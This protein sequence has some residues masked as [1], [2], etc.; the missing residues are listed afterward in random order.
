MARRRRKPN[1]AVQQRAGELAAEMRAEG[2]GAPSGAVQRRQEARRR[3]PAETDWGLVGS[4]TGRALAT[5]ATA[6]VDESVETLAEAVSTK[7][8]QEAAAVGALEGRGIF[9][10]V[11]EE[12]EGVTEG[13]ADVEVPVE[14]SWL[15][16]GFGVKA[17]TT[18]A[19][20]MGAGLVQLV[21]GAALWGGAAKG[22]RMAL[23]GRAAAKAVGE[24]AKPTTVAKGA[25]KGAVEGQVAFGLSDFAA[26]DADDKRML[27]VMNEMPAMA[28]FIPDFLAAEDP[29]DP[30]WERR[31]YRMAEG[32]GLGGL[33]GGVLGGAWSAVRRGAHAQRAGRP[34]D[35]L[36]HPAKAQ[37]REMQ[38]EAA[39]VE[40]VR[41]EEQLKE[42]D[43][44]QAVQATGEDAWARIRAMEEQLP[45][46]EV[47]LDLE[48]GAPVSQLTE[49]EVWA[50][51]KEGGDVGEEADEGLDVGVVGEGVEA[52][53]AAARPARRVLA[54][55]WVVDLSPGGY[56]PKD[57]PKIEV[58]LD[59][60]DAPT[61][62]GLT[63][64]LALPEGVRE[65]L[66]LVERTAVARLREAEVAPDDAVRAARADEAML[67]WRESFAEQISAAREVEV[68]EGVKWKPPILRMLED[69]QARVGW[70]QAQ[71]IAFRDEGMVHPD[72]VE[73]APIPAGAAARPK[74]YATQRR[75]K[76]SEMQATRP[77]DFGQAPGDELLESQRPEMMDTILLGEGD[78]AVLGTG[79]EAAFEQ[80][81]DV[82]FRDIESIDDVTGLRDAVA[83]H[84]PIGERIR[85]LSPDEQAAALE[86]SNLKRET[87]RRQEG[88]TAGEMRRLRSQ[89]RGAVKKK[90]EAAVAR[91][92]SELN[93]QGEFAAAISR[94]YDAMGRPGSGAPDARSADDVLRDVFV[95]SGYGATLRARRADLDPKLALHMVE[96]TVGS[97]QRLAK[98]ASSDGASAAQRAI[99]IRAMHKADAVIQWVKG[100][101]RAAKAAMR[102]AKL[103]TESDFEARGFDAKV[104]RRL[105]DNKLLAQSGGTQRVQARM[106]G[107][108]LVEDVSEALAHMNAWRRDAGVAWNLGRAARVNNIGRTAMMVRLGGILSRPG[109]TTSGALGNTM[110]MLAQVPERFLAQ[111]M[112]AVGS[113]DTRI[114]VRQAFAEAALQANDQMAGMVEGVMDGMRM[115]WEDAQINLRGAE[116]GAQAR[117]RLREKGLRILHHEMDRSNRIENATDNTVAGVRRDLQLKPDTK[118]AA[119][120]EVMGTVLRGAAT[121]NVQVQRSVDMIFKSMN[122]RGEIRRLAGA[123]ARAAAREGEQGVGVA[124]HAAELARNPTEDMFQ[125][126]VGNAHTNTFTAEGV[127]W[128]EGYSRAMRR[129]PVFRH[130]TPIVKTPMNVMTE[131]VKRL[132]FAHKLIRTEKEAWAKGGIARR[133]VL[134]RQ[135]MGT[136]VYGTILPLVLNDRLTGSEPTDPQEK[137]AWRALGKR[138]YSIKLPGTDTWFNYT[139][140]LGPHALP[141]AI[142]ANTARM[143]SS[144]DGEDETRDNLEA[145]LSFT[146]AVLGYMTDE[147][148]LGNM[149]EWT[150]LLKGALEG[151]ASPDRT[152][153]TLGRWAESYT[154]LSALSRSVIREFVDDAVLMDYERSGGLGGTAETL[155]EKVE[156]AVDTTALRIFDLLTLGGADDIYERLDHHG[157]PLQ[158][159]KTGGSW[160]SWL[161]PTRY[162]VESTDRIDVAEHSVGFAPSRW[163]MTIDVRHPVKSVARNMDLPTMTVE[164]TPKEKHRLQ[165]DAGKHYRKAAES[166][167]GSRE[168]ERS[169]PGVR[170]RNLEVLLS[171]ARRR[172]RRDARGRESHRYPELNRDVVDVQTKLTAQAH[173]M[174]RRG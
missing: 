97:L 66:S 112:M 14:V 81:L 161:T 157:R 89:L 9:M 168:W 47:R 27:T 121:H 143:V 11:E 32:I 102:R 147:T 57:A 135:I 67:A 158:L 127:G 40:Q 56:R 155:S 98:A 138:P 31:F 38:E 36:D 160:Q 109:T 71:R 44:T 83:E 7:E 150:D 131:G 116:A 16:D 163:D 4:E 134:G 119:T 63:R 34:G 41:I 69:E 145:T 28:R 115:G 17:P 82:Y 91:L 75:V 140:P 111:S 5:G 73:S 86:R 74:V 52:A 77:A 76:V 142:A 8:A 96:S 129:W 12:R 165:Q 156:E 173:K 92:E 167:V 85:E 152:L 61:L 19:G 132:P 50:K 171:T 110:M 18:A 139:Y 122:Y 174:M 151:D 80:P 1:R 6:A 124:E 46:G 72:L 26:F 23:G 21:V 123:R 53:P 93:Q 43:A 128:L 37:I 103:A 114:P 162:T 164:P 108:A 64:E 159:T 118:L 30:A 25:V 60:L 172:A 120:A 100:N 87:L 113:A 20:E 13:A 79:R 45:E 42:V 54:P 70:E 3:A 78:R 154:P 117:D 166:Y 39:V 95:R 170:R 35:V 29:D 137:A 90:D 84:H 136:A 125:E 105:W 104:K 65:S 33:A 48:E 126:A 15:R 51:I 58:A 141:M 130:M 24:V 55:S 153:R 10:P 107:L 144:W 99:A 146:G 2:T 169:P 106:A 148:F 68:S 88:E 101:D 22:A 49:A 149:L 94:E 133:E 59:G 62:S